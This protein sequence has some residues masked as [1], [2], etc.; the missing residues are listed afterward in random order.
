MT[1]H[2]SPQARILWDTVSDADQQNVL[3][4]VWCGHCGTATTMR[5]VAGTIKDGDLIL[6][7]QCSVCG[8]QVARLLEVDTRKNPTNI[9]QG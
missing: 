6:Q 4:N 1:H 3:A 2:F 9:Q 5:D 8:R 7:G